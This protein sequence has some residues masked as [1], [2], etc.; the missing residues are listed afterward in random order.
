MEILDKVYRAFS[1]LDRDFARSKKS[2]TEFIL[3]KFGGDIDMGSMIILDAISGIQEP[4]TEDIEKIT[5][6]KEIFKQL[7][8]ARDHL[9]T[10][11]DFQFTNGALF[12]ELMLLLATSKANGMRQ[13]EIPQADLLNESG[14]SIHFLALP[15][16]CVYSSID[17]AKVYS[18]FNENMQLSLTARCR[19][20]DLELGS[21]Y[22]RKGGSQVVAISSKGLAKAVM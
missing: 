8:D 11:P 2:R 20:A 1:N 18:I 13:T 12:K 17:A 5:F 14:S 15:G 10:L 16:G 21:Y 4:S 9:D 19:G 22:A 3:D 7:S 6:V